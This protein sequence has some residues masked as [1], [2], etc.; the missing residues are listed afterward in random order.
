MQRPRAPLVA[1]R[2]AGSRAWR[3]A[4]SIVRASRRSVPE[5]VRSCRR[6]HATSPRS[7]LPLRAGVI[8]SF[9]LEVSCLA[10]VWDGGAFWQAVNDKLAMTT[11][12]DPTR[13]G[14]IRRATG[15]HRIAAIIPRLDATVRRMW[16]SCIRWSDQPR[17]I[18]RHTTAR[19]ACLGAPMRS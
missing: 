1:L 4:F 3:T 13:H 5:A 15:R 10:G 18:S 8:S 19:T 11:A 6:R 17:V 12:S 9:T 16:L 7:I 2:L 14:M